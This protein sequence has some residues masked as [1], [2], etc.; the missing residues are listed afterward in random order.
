MHMYYI[1]FSPINLILCQFYYF[2]ISAAVRT[3]EE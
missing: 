1:G 3:K 2:I